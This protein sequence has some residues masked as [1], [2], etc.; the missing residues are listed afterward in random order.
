MSDVKIAQ[1]VEKADL[2]QMERMDIDDVYVLMDVQLRE[3]PD[4]RELYKRWEKQN[5]AAYDVDFA[6]DRD[7]WKL[8]PAEMKEQLIFGFLGFFLGEAAVTD[9]L[10]PLVMAAPTDEDRQF[11]ATQ[12][13]DEA[14][15]TILFER[16]FQEVLGID[17]L[18]AAREMT[19]EMGYTANADRGYARLFYNDL[20]RVTDQCR[21]DPTNY[22]HFVESITL[23][24]M[25]IEGMLALAGQ[26][27]I[28]QI[29]RQFKVL[30]GFRAGFTAVTRDESRHVNY[31]VYALWRAVEAG[32]HDH[33]VDSASRHMQAT[34]D[35]I[36]RPF[37]KIPP[38]PAALS[39]DFRIRD[40]WA[41]SVHQLR[42]RLRGAGVREDALHRLEGEWWAVIESNLDWY[43]EHYGEPHP[44]R[45]QDA[46][47]V[48]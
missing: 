30:P 23:Y 11:L 10:S 16:F 19:D 33:I 1:E 44:A 34:A 25:L 3:R 13:V 31:G 17:G 27:R 6:K 21:L 43:E 24:H 47:A 15:H 8:F 35:I 38:I 26:R 9:T 36:S 29:A 5:W 32:L 48:A 40:G 4:A 39:Q 45:L 2:Q 28:L 18:R 14:R 41:F 20:V 46:E 37:R 42:K 12:L 22:H 7:D